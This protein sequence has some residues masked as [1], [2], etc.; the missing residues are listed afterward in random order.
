MNFFTSHVL[1]ERK[2]ETRN[3]HRS[4]WPNL[5]IFLK[6][7]LQFWASEFIICYWLSVLLDQSHLYLV[8]CIILFCSSLK[9]KLKD[10]MA[11]FQ[12]C[13]SRIFCFRFFPQNLPFFNLIFFFKIFADPERSHPSRISWGC[14][15]TRLYRLELFTY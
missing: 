12:V 1:R 10:K 13:L 8:F 5:R 9:K 15:E 14:W 4:R 2:L 3:V 6:Q 7:G 11:E